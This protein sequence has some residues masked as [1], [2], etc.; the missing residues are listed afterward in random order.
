MIQSAN[1]LRYQQ[2]GCPICRQSFRAL[3]QIRAVRKKTDHQPQLGCLQGD[4]ASTSRV[5]SPAPTD[6][7]AAT[8]TNRTVIVKAK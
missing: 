2:S 5:N 6:Q 1:Q 4:G 8:G 3:L 7:Q